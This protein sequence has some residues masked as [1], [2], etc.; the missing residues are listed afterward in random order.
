M[1]QEAHPPSSRT[2]AE[3]HVHVEQVDGYE[4]RVQFDN[5]RWSQLLLDEPPPLGRDAGPNASRILAAAVANCLC[6]SLL[7]CAN[8]AGVG[9]GPID[10]DVTVELARNEQ[11]RLRIGKI[12]VTLRPTIESNGEVDAC[13]ASFEDF[14]VVTQS[15]RAGIDVD[16][17]VEPT[18][19]GAE[20]A[21]S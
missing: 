3:L 16:V 17:S 21:P 2:V 4:F 14:C 5:E 13:L 12:R 1:T 19:I 15:V 8:K 20:V 9:I 7:F 10:A 11:R 6:A 18:L